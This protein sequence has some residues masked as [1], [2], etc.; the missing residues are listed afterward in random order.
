MTYYYARFN[1]H[2]LN[3][4][5]YMVFKIILNGYFFLPRILFALSVP[6]EIEINV[7]YHLSSSS[8]EEMKDQN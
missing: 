3:S 6:T 1:A 2:V 8:T 7:A 4:T 5:L